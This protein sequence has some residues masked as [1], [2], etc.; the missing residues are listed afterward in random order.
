MALSL[1][2]ATMDTSMQFENADSLGHGHEQKANCTGGNFI[3]REIMRVN[4]IFG[5]MILISAMAC[6]QGN[7][8]IMENVTGEGSDYR[9]ARLDAFRNAI[10]KAYGVDIKSVTQVDHF[11]AI[12][13]NILSRSEGF[14]H[15]CEGEEIEQKNGVYVVSFK[16]IVIAESAKTIVDKIKEISEGLKNLNYP[17]FGV[18]SEGVDTCFLGHI[19]AFLVKQLSIKVVPEADCELTI[20]PSFYMDKDELAISGG[21][22]NKKGEIISSSA[23]FSMRY[24]GESDKKYAAHILLIDLLEQIIVAPTIKVKNV[25]SYIDAGK[26]KQKIITVDVVI[27]CGLQK[28]EKET[29]HYSLRIK[30]NLDMLC[31]QLIK[32][33]IFD[34]VDVEMDQVA[35]ILNLRYVDHRIETSPDIARQETGSKS[36]VV[37]NDLKKIGELQNSIKALQ[38]RVQALESEVERLIKFENKEYAITLF[39]NDKHHVKIQQ[40]TTSL[41]DRG[42][43]VHVLQIPV[44]KNAC[45]YYVSSNAPDET[46]RKADYVLHIVRQYTEVSLSQE[47]VRQASIEKEIRIFL[48]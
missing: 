13:D 43:K 46:R 2:D 39:T 33:N 22:T 25:K 23:P 34:S 48:K 30:G 36:Q 14:I 12:V 37:L 26:V 4:L 7:Y 47:E 1:L 6:A 3:G 10:E 11:T 20:R 17:S 35:R 5:L 18:V 32:T 16:R 24:F 8:K 19:R 41:K 28:Y 21:I 15:S 29:A 9:R 45:T 38:S 44:T 42:F 27:E 31:S 40:I